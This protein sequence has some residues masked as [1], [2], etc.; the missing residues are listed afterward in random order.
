MFMIFIFLIYN[1]ILKV[2]SSKNTSKL[3]SIKFKTFH[4]LTYNRLYNK[5]GFDKEDL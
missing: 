4:P 1:N 3:A 2:K 5:T